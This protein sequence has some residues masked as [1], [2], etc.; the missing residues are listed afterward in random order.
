VSLTFGKVG[1][2]TT[3]WVKSV[4]RIQDG[5]LGGIGIG[6]CRRRRG[7]GVGVSWGRGWDVFLKRE[8]ALSAGK[9]LP[10][11]KLLSLRCF[12]VTQRYSYLPL[13][14]V[15]LE[16]WTRLVCLILLARPIS[17]SSLAG[18]QSRHMIMRDVAV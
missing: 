2:T 14:R 18:D 6:G 7:V 3:K 17:Y 9:L 11:E 5:G 12:L 8:E 16:T 1:N 15:S 10:F 4:Q 13:P